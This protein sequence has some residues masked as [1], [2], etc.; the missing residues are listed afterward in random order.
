[1]K[2]YWEFI[3]EM[4]RNIGDSSYSPMNLYADHRKKLYN[5]SLNST[6][7]KFP[8]PRNK[9]IEVFHYKNSDGE[10]NYVTNDHKSKE[11]LHQSIIKTDETLEKLPFPYQEQNQV[12][13]VKSTDVLPK[14]YAKD[15]IYDHFKESNLPLKSSDTQFLNGHNMWKKLAHKALNDGHHVYYYDGTTLHKSTK[16]SVDKHLDSSFGKEERKNGKIISP[17]YEARH[18]I[19]SK[20]EL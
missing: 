13:R 14:D 2:K 3:E 16:D 7:H 18:M 12:D 9:N 10:D 6:H 1:M 8:I 4:A 19:L 20:H 11:A 15:F 17:D 5:H